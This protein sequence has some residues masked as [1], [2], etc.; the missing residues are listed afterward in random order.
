[1]FK[2]AEAKAGQ[3]CAAQLA[4]KSNAFSGSAPVT[5]SSLKIE[6]DGSLR[7][8]EVEHEA[9]GKPADKNTKLHISHVSLTEKE[10]EGEDESDDSSSI[11]SQTKS[12]FLLYGSDNLTIAPGQTLV[13]G[14][15]I[16]LREPG[17][18]RATQ[19]RAAVQDDSFSLDYTIALPE[20]SNTGVWHT[21]LSTKK[22]LRVN[23]QHVHVLPRPPKMELR[24]VK[25]MQQY[26]TDEAIRLELQLH[27]AED[28]DADA[29]L[30]MSVVG[31]VV[32]TYHVQ[33]DGLKESSKS[34]GT[35][36]GRLNNVSIGQ[37]QKSGV[38]SAFITFDPID[39]PTT[40]EI[41]AKVLYYLVS[42]PATPI[43]QEATFLLDVVTPFEANF[44]LLPRVHSEWPSLFDYEAVQEAK[45]DRE[46]ADQPTGLAHR[47][48]LVT[49]YASF[50]GEDL[51]ISNLSMKVI[52]VQGGAVCTASRDEPSGAADLIISPKTIE[53]A[54]FDIV[55]QKLSLDDR[56]PSTADLSF[57]ID[58]HRLD[59]SG[60]VGPLNTTS[61]PLPRFFVTV[62]E[63]R[64]LAR[65]TYTS[66]LVPPTSR[67]SSTPSSNT[68]AQV[69]APPT[70]AP[71]EDPPLV[72]LE[73]IV[74]NPSSHFLTFGLTMEL[75]DDFA[76]SG[77]K[78]TTLNVLPLARR[79]A[80]YRLL[81]LVRGAWVRPS[82]VVRDK[83]FQKVLRIIPTEGMKSD[84]EGVLFWVP[85][86]PEDEEEESRGEDEE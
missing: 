7:T 28:A 15:D 16:P 18:A 4:I 53:E 80:T 42:D 85:P 17:D 76:F 2:H 57:A 49:R 40:V 21:P 33:V 51:R 55:A 3:P 32:P 75:S 65:V 30:D 52:A 29:K 9:A 67:T 73:I 13:F 5:F 72:M 24:F 22:V 77:A 25:S 50:A 66:P 83:Y 1:M 44:D 60:S 62:S 46:P 11:V 79:S 20:D 78:T 58:W 35:D 39:R 14:M 19:I 74:E 61:L 56:A 68:A 12:A 27:N 45:D 43:T 81:P 41:A 63:P 23:A 71:L 37:I 69:S 34:S 26:Y 47:W 64:V 84:K 82:L 38:S 6:F 31:Q 36:S 59:A 48:S 10:L 8:I 70:A 86:A 54:S